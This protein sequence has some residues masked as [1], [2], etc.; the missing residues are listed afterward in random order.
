MKVCKKRS[1]TSQSLYVVI[2]QDQL[3]L[4]GIKEGD[5]VCVVA[6]EKKK[7][8]IIKKINKGE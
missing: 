2:P 8:I 3:K 6:S 7:E 1:N 4:V 5:D